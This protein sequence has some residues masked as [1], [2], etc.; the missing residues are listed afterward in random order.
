MRIGVIGAG[1]AG[2]AAAYDFARAGHGVT[3]YEA[4][5]FVGGQASTIEVGG[6]RLERGYHHLFTSDN[7]ILEI[8]GS[9]SWS[10]GDLT[11]KLFAH[12]RLHNVYEAALHETMAHVELLVRHQDVVQTPE[13]RFVGTGTQHYLGVLS[14]A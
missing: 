2:L 5:P 14:S 12:R 11:K 1:A 4:A 9:S 3:V 6:G 13:N 8:M 10:L 7:A